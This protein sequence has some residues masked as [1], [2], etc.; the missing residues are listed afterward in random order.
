VFEAGFYVSLLSFSS[1]WCDSASRDIRHRM[2]IWP[3]S[4]VESL[5]VVLAFTLLT[6][7][8]LRWFYFIFP[9]FRGFGRIATSATVCSSSCCGLGSA[10]ALLN[11]LS[12][13]KND[14]A[15]FYDRFPSML[16]LLENILRPVCLI[17]LRA[18]RS[19][20]W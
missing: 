5:K 4:K 1:S 19:T 10:P 15:Y 2:H 9:L 18:M 12:N 13:V 8:L 17:T 14:W 7:G 16:V 3:V 6:R 20:C 11:S